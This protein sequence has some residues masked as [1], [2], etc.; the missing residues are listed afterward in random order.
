MGPLSLWNAGIETSAEGFAR[1]Q[2]MMTAFPWP[3][4]GGATGRLYAWGVS[5]AVLLLHPAHW[6]DAGAVGVR[7]SW[8]RVL[9]P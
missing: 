8:V 7:W 6:R 1:D 2:A 5:T 4:Y 9:P 3:A